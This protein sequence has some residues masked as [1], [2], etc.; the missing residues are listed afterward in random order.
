M[1]G[2]SATYDANGNLLQG[3]GHLATWNGADLA[4]TLDAD[5]HVYGANRGRVKSSSEA[6]TRMELDDLYEI[7]GLGVH[8]KYVKIGHRLVAKK[9]GSTK[10]WIHTDHRGSVRGLTNAAQ[11]PVVPAL[12]GRGY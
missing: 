10:Y 9:T 7:S 8:T 2:S 1:D 12:A 3:A 6:S 4:R 11:L 5:Q